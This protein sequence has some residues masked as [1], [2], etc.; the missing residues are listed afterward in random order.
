MNARMQ[1]AAWLYYKIYVGDIAGGLDYLITET[2]PKLARNDIERWFFVRYLDEEGLHLRLRVKPSDGAPDLR[3]VLKLI[4]EDS[5]RALP[6][7]PPPFYQPVISTPVAARLPRRSPIRAVEDEY[8]PEI[9]MFGAMGIAVAERL[10]HLSSEIAM[11]VLIDERA[12]LYSRKTLAPI[13]MKAVCDTF[14]PGSGAPFWHGYSKYWLQISRESADAWA[15]RFER[16][17]RE[18]HSRA[19][20]VVT[21]DAALPESARNA[22]KTWR[23][24]LSQAA[25]DFEALQ[26]PPFASGRRRWRPV[27]AIL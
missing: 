24:G 22:V 9:A 3:P 12:D 23:A 20:P 19:L 18:L 6:K 1:A 13:F 5:L 17:A 15:Q 26:E 4:I 2:L 27:S 25:S 14:L 10:F 21:P 11:A 7:A 16:K 8:E